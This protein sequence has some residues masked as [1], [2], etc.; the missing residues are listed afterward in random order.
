MKKIIPFKNVDE[1]IE[2]LDNGGRFYNL[3]A[4]ED[5]GKISASEVGKLAGVFVDNQQLVLYFD[6]AAAHLSA[7]EKDLVVSKMTAN[8]QKT[9]VK[10]TTDRSDISDS[11][12]TIAVSRNVIVE[13]APTLVDSKS[14][15]VGFI[16]VPIMVG[17][18]MIF[19]LVPIT[20]Q[21]DVYELRGGVSTG[22]SFPVAHAA[23][24]EKLQP[25]NM[26]IGGVMKELRSSKEEKIPTRKFLEILYIVE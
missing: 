16:M 20:E 3:F 13:G 6:I 11:F 9:Y 5:D 26:L 7:V 21:Y 12:H 1:A 17:K 14:E 2:A 23:A 24:K 19:S 4:K 15:L 10:Y 8:M 25:K 18:V 22:N